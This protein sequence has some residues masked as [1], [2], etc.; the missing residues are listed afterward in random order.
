[1]IYLDNSATTRIDERVLEAMLPWLGDNYGNPSSTH[2]AGRRARVAV[3]QARE[4]IAQLI[5]AHPA[6]IIFTSGGTESNNTVIRSAFEESHLIDSLA[7]SSVEHHAVLAPAEH[8][9]S[10]GKDVQFLGVDEHGTLNAHEVA[11][12]NNKRR[13]LSV[14]HSNNETGVMND[15]A[16]LRAAAPDCLL[17]SDAVQSFGKVPLDVQEL[18]LDFASLS[19]HKIHGPKGVGALFIRKGIDFKAHQL[20]GGQ[21]RNRR[22]GTEAVSNIIGFQVAARLACAEMNA[23][24]EHCSSIVA[25]MRQAVIESIPNVRINTPIEDALPTLL[26]MSFPDANAFDGDAILQLMDLHGVAC[27]NGSACVSGTMQ[28]SHVLIAMGRSTAE[29]RA[30]VRFS[31]SQ[32]TTQAEALEAIT[33][34]A[35]VIRE[36]RSQSDS[37][38]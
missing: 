37:S 23:R 38:H 12:I 2:A 6:E 27:S 21:E 33:I 18:G 20:G 11:A 1:M 26:H 30:A 36:L 15:V 16:S 25:A 13:L 17:H 9:Q 10:L 19:A 32:Y 31:V 24:R 7:V 28:P 3:E 34:L 8:M 4:E 14:M 29:A 5:N 35:T 22:A